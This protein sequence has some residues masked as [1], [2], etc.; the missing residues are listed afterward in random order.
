[1]S[2]VFKDIDYGNQAQR[3][4][5]RVSS[6]ETKVAA[7]KAKKDARGNIEKNVGLLKAS[8][9]GQKLT[10]GLLKGAKPYLTQQKNKAISSIKDGVQKISDRLTGT[11]RELANATKARDSIQ[12]TNENNEQERIA[13]ETDAQNKVDNAGEDG[14]DAAKAEQTTLQT[15]NDADRATE[16]SALSD[17]N[18]AVDAAQEGSTVADSV[19]SKVAGNAVKTA[20]K[21][22]GK[23][24][25]KEAGEDAAVEGGAVA[26]EITGSEAIGAA[27]DAT[28]LGAP[29]GIL[30]GALGIGIGARQESEKRAPKMAPIPL[31]QS[32]ATFQAGISQ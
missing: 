21:D 5:S 30:I 22:A 31:N 17:A 23:A 18:S 13:Q 32:G 1:M 19:V 6:A 15:A 27:L 12:Q 20:A 7:L 14:V 28:G 26:A 16:A 9:G 11:N 2:D 24:V 25:A 29:L 4:L 10:E 8:L 3:L